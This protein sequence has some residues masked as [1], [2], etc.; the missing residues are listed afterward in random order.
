MTGTWLTYA[1]SIIVSSV[2]SVSRVE[3]SWAVCSSQ[4]SLKL[5]AGMIE[6]L[7]RPGSQQP[8]QQD[9]LAHVISVVIRRQQRLPQNRL[10][11]AVR[12]RREQIGFRIR[13]QRD[14]RFEIRSKFPQALIPRTVRRR[15]FGIRPVSSGELWRDVLRVPAELQDV[16]LGDAHVL[17]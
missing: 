5:R 8:A 1:S 2:R 14:H 4:S 11:V 6:R 16:P 10:S 15:R 12:D 3:N 7:L 13:N 9:Q 17:E